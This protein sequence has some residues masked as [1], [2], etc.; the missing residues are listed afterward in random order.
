MIIVKSLNSRERD[1]TLI[2]FL[3]EENSKLAPK[4][5]L[6]NSLSRFSSSY[7]DGI[8]SIDRLMC[9]IF[10]KY[11]GVTEKLFSLTQHLI[12]SPLTMALAQNSLT[13]FSYASSRV[14]SRK[15]QSFVANHMGIFVS[16]RDG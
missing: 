8:E 1:A 4:A 5:Y 15:F 12:F 11:I 9:K 14:E 3:F 10:A 6:R 7:T 2:D 13:M 16:W